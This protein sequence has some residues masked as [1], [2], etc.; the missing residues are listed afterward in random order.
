M[1]IKKFTPQEMEEVAEVLRQAFLAVHRNLDPEYQKRID[2]FWL[3]LL[4]TGRPFMMVTTEGLAA[5]TKAVFGDDMQR[6]FVMN[7]TSTFFF[8]WGADNDTRLAL[9]R[10]LSQSVCVDLGVFLVKPSAYRAM[11]RANSDRLADANDAYEVLVAN[12][13]LAVMAMST[14]FMPYRDFEEKTTKPTRRGVAP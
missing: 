2:E 7:L 4:K 9:M 11:P 1:D 3:R 13:W 12:S 8:M 10:N 14:M 6:D 5:Y